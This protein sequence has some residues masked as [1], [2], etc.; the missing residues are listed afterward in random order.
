[1]KKSQFIMLIA[2]LMGI[3]L[4]GILPAADL[5]DEKHEG[6]TG[7][8]DMVKVLNDNVQA[9]IVYQT[10]GNLLRTTATNTFS[11]AFSAAPLVIVTSVDGTPT[12]N[13]VTVTASS[14]TIVWGATNISYKL[15]A[16][17]PVNP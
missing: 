2:L 4:I 7:L 12:T 10:Q 16:I 15:I 14:A 1:M 5:L 13:A 3:G 8:K 6:K 17:G 9:K 11:P